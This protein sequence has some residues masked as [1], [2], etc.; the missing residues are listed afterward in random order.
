[1]KRLNPK[2]GL[3]K[4]RKR[5]HIPTN[6]EL[7]KIVLDY[8][9]YK[10]WYVN[11]NKAIKEFFHDDSL[12][13]KCIAV[14][15]QQNDLKNN[16]DFAIIAYQYIKN[17]RNLKEVNFGIAN[18]AIQINL[19]RVKRGQ[20]PQGNKIRPFSL[21]LRGDLS[22]VVI[23]THMTKF[24]TNNKK[25]VPCRTDIRHINTIIRKLSSDLNLKPSETQSCI[26][27]YIKLNMEYSREKT[28]YDY[29]YFLNE[30]KR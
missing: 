21:A 25:K 29:S 6:K 17:N 26:W 3:K 18:S 11:S 28:D 19:N 5:N 4:Y 10:N 30:L 22:Q 27:S 12:F 15:S 16:V 20:L 7:R 2:I 1:M 13:I 8:I 14:T 23:D 24:F 9:K